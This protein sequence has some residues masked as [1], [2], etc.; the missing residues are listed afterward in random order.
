MLLIF[1]G[2]KVRGIEVFAKEEGVKEKLKFC[3][4]IKQEV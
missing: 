1:I 4:K 3:K 2:W